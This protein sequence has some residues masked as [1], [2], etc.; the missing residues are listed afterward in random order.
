MTPASAVRVTRGAFWSWQGP[1]W[2]DPGMN[3][4]AGSVPWAWEQ[5]RVWSLTANR[6][7]AGI[8]R[9][10]ALGLG[11]GLVAA[12]T[13]VAAAQIAGP[14]P[15]AGRALGAVAAIAAGLA[16][17]A[18]RGAGTEQIRAWTRTR[19][20]SEALKTEVYAYLAG[21]SA[22]TGPD[23]EQKLDN[24]ARDLVA[25]VGDLQ[26]HALGV[27][28]DGKPIPT[29]SGLY[30]YL[31]ARVDGQVNDY[32]RPKSVLYEAR[33][34][35]LRRLGTALGVLTVVLASVAASFD[36]PGVTAWVPVATTATTAVAAHISAARY[37]HL[38]IGYLRTAQR[39]E[40]LRATPSG[41]PPPPQL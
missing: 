29:V 18:Q 5:Q 3:E 37:D 1:G 13:A 12:V 39:L 9:A 22:Y 11:L 20:A 32:Y 38:I 34:R 33:V 15:W 10:R 41:T 7:K 25:A 23:R 2:Q 4:A 19:S 16:T 6:L 36:L 14:A 17:M 30:D 40:H 27:T 28:P 24:R 31:T 35:R 21:G 8:D 26:R